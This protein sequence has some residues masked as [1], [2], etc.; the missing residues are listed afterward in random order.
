MCSTLRLKHTHTLNFI[1]RSEFSAVFW[2]TFY[3]VQAPLRSTRQ[4]LLHLN[5]RGVSLVTVSQRCLYAAALFGS[6]RLCCS[7]ASNTALN[8][9]VAAS[10]RGNFSSLLQVGQVL[11]FFQSSL[12][13]LS[14]TVSPA[15]PPAALPSLVED[16]EF[17]DVVNGISNRPLLRVRN[18]GLM[19][20]GIR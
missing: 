1:P 16:T 11:H 20:S 4:L 12:P 5:P 6:T 17:A 8:L 19:S 14:T 13:P 9:D 10:Q 18:V 3:A 15:R 7:T 2:L